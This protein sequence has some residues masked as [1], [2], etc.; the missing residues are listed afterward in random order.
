MIGGLLRREEIGLPMAEARG[1]RS[2]RLAGR[3]LDGSGRPPAW[4]NAGAAMPEG[5]LPEMVPAGASSYSFGSPG[6]L[7]G[8][9]R[10][11]AC[12]I[13]FEEKFFLYSRL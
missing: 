12:N 11:N 5:D 10:V 7:T 4:H 9:M 1:S 3:R 13:R 6:R 2:I 8:R